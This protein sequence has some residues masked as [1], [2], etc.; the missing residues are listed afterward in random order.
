MSRGRLSGEIYAALLINIGD[1]DP[2][3]VSDVKHVFNLL[4]AAVFKL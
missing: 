4:D 2:G 3:H 1:L